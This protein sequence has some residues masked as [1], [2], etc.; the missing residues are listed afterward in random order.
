MRITPKTEEQIKEE[1][2]V[3]WPAG[4]YE[5]EVVPDATLGQNMV[6]TKDDTS[7]KGNDMIV[8][9]LRVYNAKGQ[10]RIIIDYLLEAMAFKLRHACEACG[11][12]AKYQGGELHAHDFVGKT[13]KLKLKIQPAKGE[14]K[15]KNVVD[16][17]IVSANAHTVAKGNGFQPQA[18]ALDDEIPF[19]LLLPLALSLLSVVGV[20]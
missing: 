7:A 5:F 14:Y 19:A 18:E 3:N 20:A 13:G 16:D 8:L 17:Y 2:N 11:L 15:E 12:L 10:S 6:Y 9:V 1:S 4:E